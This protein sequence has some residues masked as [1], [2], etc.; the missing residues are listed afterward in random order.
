VGS[1]IDLALVVVTL[2]FFF[3]CWFYVRACER[4]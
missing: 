1:M 2:L 4:V 3:V